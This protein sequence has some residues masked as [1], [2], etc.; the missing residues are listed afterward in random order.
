MARIRVGNGFGKVTFAIALNRSK[1]GDVIVLDPGHYETE[2]KTL[3]GVSIQGNGAA[4]LIELTGSFV[5]AQQ[6]SFTSLTLRALHYKNA[7]YMDRP[8]STAKITDCVV[9]TEPSGKYPALWS[10]SGTMVLQGVTAHSEAGQEAVSLRDGATLH[11]TSSQLGHI[12]A[13]AAKVE[14]NNCTTRYIE[15]TKESRVSALNGHRSV[16]SEGIRDFMVSGRSVLR[17]EH[18]IL[19]EKYH[20]GSAHDS[21]V[22]IDRLSQ[23][24][25]GQFATM[26]ASGARVITSDKAIKIV[27]EDAK[28][29]PEPIP[30]GPKTVHWPIGEGNNFSSKILPQLNIGDT[31]QLDAGDYTL[32]D[33][34][35]L[36]LSF[37][38]IGQ[39]DSVTRIHGT[40]G[41]APSSQ[42][43]VSDLTICAT[44]VNRHAVWLFNNE[45]HLVLDKVSVRSAPNP[46]VAGLYA[47][48]GSVSLYGCEFDS[49]NNPIGL[50]NVLLSKNARLDA[51]DTRLGWFDTRNSASAT[52]SACSSF[53][54]AAYSG[55][56]ITV[57]NSHHLVENDINAYGL[58]VG[59]N[60]HITIPLLTSSAACPDF[61]LDGGNILLEK[62]G[63]TGDENFVVHRTSGEVK[64]IEEGAYSLF[65]KNEDTLELVHSTT[66]GL[67]A[68]QHDEELASEAASHIPVAEHPNP[69]S[70]AED[71]KELESAKNASPLDDLNSLIGLMKVKKQV[72]TFVNMTKLNQKRAELCIP[73]DDEFTLHSMFLGNPGTGKTTVARLVGKAMSQAGVVASDKFVETRRSELVSDNIGGTAKLT[74]KVLESG[75]GGVIFIDE[76]YDLASED[77]AGF[78]EEAVSE[79]MTFMEN[80]RSTTMVIFAG[81]TK[82]MHDLLAVN[83]G[84]KSRIKHRFEFEDYS[85]KEMV[86]IGLAELAKGHFTVNE[87]LYSRVIGS[88]YSRTADRSNARWARNFNQDLRTRQGERVI[89]L[90]DPTRDDLLTILDA[91]LHTMAGEAPEALQNRLDQSL[92]ELDALTGLAPVKE[93]VR[94]LVEQAVVNKHLMELDGSSMRPNY[95]VAFTGNPGTG[96]TTVARI[97]SE[98]FYSLQILSTS[99][100]QSVPAT[101][102]LGKYIGHSADNVHNVIDAAMGGVLFVD[103]AH[104]L[105]TGSNNDA[106][107][108]EV[109]DSMITR[110]EDDRDKFVAIFAGYTD[111]M[112]E[113][114][115]SD[116]GLKSRIPSEIEFPDYTPDEVAEIANAV[117]AKNWQFNAEL[118]K[119]IASALYASLE[120]ADQSN[121]RWAR[122]FTEA[123]VAR[124]NRYLVSNNLRGEAMKQ[125]PNEILSSFQVA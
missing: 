117:L 26:I 87:E 68:Q 38:L 47:E 35:C 122:S 29:A 28:P 43:T 71:A 19:D 14:L 79:I 4:E 102:L 75:R 52:L 49:V 77:S 34:S 86:Q 92:T 48:D 25:D 93:W 6:S 10:A 37:N 16:P 100:V 24:S 112:H 55:S 106:F 120:P 12:F 114:F 20:E 90:E 54:L 27:D 65:Q 105:R 111:Q 31:V 74:R 63:E 125:I 23:D 124:H 88:A 13:A 113:F 8:D 118:F 94:G 22:H 58:W 3:N 21:V 62:F 84:L 39:G 67:A 98:I 15:L 97:V 99:S 61:R 109:V 40:I 51:E 7:I 70:G 64:G 56:V 17:F 115:A 96:K 11:A 50:S 1:P 89:M 41:M 104:Q 2:P 85:P 107:R 83:E 121:G 91:D 80:N 18:L 116:P 72:N 101:Q 76:A 32:D 53:N 66:R 5:I 46:E 73:T 44:S 110:L 82:K 95:H 45:S 36:E 57:R 59:E 69:T 30:A 78:A 103:E 119:E 42:A 81:Y 108:K 60:S 33:Y 123:V 9:I